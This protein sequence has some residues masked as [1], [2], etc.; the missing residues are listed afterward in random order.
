MQC[1]QFSNVTFTSLSS[2]LTSTIDN[3]YIAAEQLGENPALCAANS[4]FFTSYT[5]C[6]NCVVANGDPTKVSLQTSVEP[7]FAPF[8]NFCS[9]QSAQPALGTG[10]SSTSTE[11]AT[12]IPV[13]SS[14]N[15]A[16][17]SLS[18]A[19]LSLLAEA[20]SLGLDLGTTEQVTSTVF[21]TPKATSSQ[22]STSTCEI[23]PLPKVQLLTIIAALAATP[24]PPITKVTTSINRAW[25]AGAVVGPI[26]FVALGILA[27]WLWRRRKRRTVVT[28]DSQQPDE[29]NKEDMIKAQLHAD[30]LQ[31]QRHE[32][33]GHTTTE[34]CNERVQELPA[35]EPVGS[36]LSAKKQVFIQRKPVSG[37]I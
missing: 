15:L 21:Y 12:P 3:A 10:A 36:E 16:Q 24:S 22:N 34:L 4:T 9:A 2:T 28:A 26:F 32:L 5:A 6:Q 27:F 30:S 18:Q 37:V 11:T 33:E 23:S 19:K 17:L 25:I 13:T 1:V 7:E 8:I 20:S 29:E 31:I 35:L 14:V